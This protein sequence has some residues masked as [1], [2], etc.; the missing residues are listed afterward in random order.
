MEL[1]KHGTQMEIFLQDP[2]PP[3]ASASNFFIVLLYFFLSPMLPLTFSIPSR[4]PSSS[5]SAPS[6]TESGVSPLSQPASCAAHSGT[7]VCW[8]VCV[9][10]RKCDHPASS[11]VKI[12]ALFIL[13]GPVILTKKPQRKSRSGGKRVD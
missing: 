11:Q 3:V 8:C 7:G 13:L 10:V 1:K 4:R 12:G 2:S 9:C 5:T 6:P